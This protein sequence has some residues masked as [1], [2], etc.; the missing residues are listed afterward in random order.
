MPRDGQFEGI[1]MTDTPVTTRLINARMV[2]TALDYH[3]IAATY[4]HA[5]ADCT[6]PPQSRT[7]FIKKASWFRM[8]AQIAS[9]K[10]A[11]ALP[12]NVFHLMAPSPYR[13]LIG[14]DI[15]KPAASSNPRKRGSLNVLNHAA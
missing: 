12:Q 14:T 6:L 11:M 7:A 9:A 3:Q 4:A 8:R 13:P 1:A 15:W 5:A 10:Q 2:L